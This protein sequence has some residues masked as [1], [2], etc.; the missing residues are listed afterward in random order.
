MKIAGFLYDQIVILQATG[1]TI[2]FSDKLKNQLIDTFYEHE[3]EV[4]SS[5]SLQKTKNTM[6]SG[7]QKMPL[8][9]ADGKL[10]L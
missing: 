4:I 5:V 8:R 9:G 2:M 10:I 7:G 6:A 1:N 3:E